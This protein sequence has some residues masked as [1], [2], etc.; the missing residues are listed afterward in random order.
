MSKSPADS[1]GWWFEAEGCGRQILNFGTDHEVA[2]MNESYTYYAFVSHSH[3]DAKWAMWIQNALERYRLPSSVRKTVRKPLPKRLVPVFRDA[4]DLGSCPLVEG[5]HRELEASRFLVVICSPDSAKPNA[6]G[7]HFVEHEVEYFIALG[8]GDRIIPVIVRGT[9]EESFCPSIRE[10]GLLAIDATKTSRARVLNDIV[11]RILGLR[12]DEL[13]RRERRRQLI[14][15]IELSVFGAV[16]VLVI[17]VGGLF[18]W[19]ATRKVENYYADYVDSYGLPEGI[20]PLSKDELRG[21]NF[22]YRFEYD[23]IRLGKSIH[24]DSSDWS[25]IRIFGFERILHKVV[26]V[27][28]NRWVSGLD[29]LGQEQHFRATVREFEYRDVAGVKRGRLA[30][31]V[32]RDP[33]GVEIRKVQFDDAILNGAVK[34]INGVVR[35]YSDFG[36]RSIGVL[37]FAGAPG[38]YCPSDNGTVASVLLER[39]DAGRVTCAKFCDAYND[40]MNVEGVSNIRYSYDMMGRCCEEWYANDVGNRVALESV[41]TNHVSGRSY[42]FEGPFLSQVSFIGTNRNLVCSEIGWTSRRYDYDGFGRRIRATCLGAGGVVKDSVR[43]YAFVLGVYDDR[44]RLITC[45][46]FDHEGIPIS[47]KLFGCFGERYCYNDL[48]QLTCRQE[49]DGSGQNVVDNACGWGMATNVFDASGRVIKTVYLDSHAEPIRTSEDVP[50]VTEYVYENGILKGVGGYCGVGDVLKSG[51]SMSSASKLTTDTNGLRK[52]EFEMRHVGCASQYRMICYL[53]KRGAPIESASVGDDGITPVPDACGVTRTYVKYRDD[54][55]TRARKDEYAD[56]GIG[57]SGATGLF[58]RVSIFN[59]AGSVVEERNFGRNGESVANSL[60][61]VHWRCDYQDDG[62]TF[63]HSEE[64]RVPNYMVT[65]GVHRLVRDYD[66]F[67]RVVDLRYF[68]PAGNLLADHLGATHYTYS[69]HGATTFVCRECSY[70]ELGT[71]NGVSCRETTYDENGSLLKI[72]SFDADGK[73]LSDLC[74]DR[75]ESVE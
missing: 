32:Y 48:D 67:G 9:P 45:R 63:R 74:E 30:R 33:F 24:A 69:Y 29:G 70:C 71:M 14:R 73:V 50:V 17:A 28:M 37:A 38:L 66:A 4:T 23:G 57:I 59:E 3:R 65:S 51:D 31:I 53:N 62:K 8:R 61:I 34:T 6:E 44:G 11:A 39:N 64:I 42:K 35:Y 5:L 58:H 46:Y 1:F 68:S 19:D 43:G 47:E 21:R 36:G 10:S 25:F 60:G 15:R 27:D 49:L 2:G 52:V 7:K 18:A 56:V 72:R 22:Y 16:A 13:W 75:S 20:F 41:S 55:T 54:L 26:E 12:P 40:A